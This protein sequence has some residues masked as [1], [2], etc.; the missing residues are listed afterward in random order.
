MYS[1]YPYIRWARQAMTEPMRLR[2][3]DGD[4][5]RAM[6]TFG[7]GRVVFLACVP[8]GWARTARLRN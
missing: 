1:I 7:T 3:L 6:V 4:R 2:R 5:R 8:V